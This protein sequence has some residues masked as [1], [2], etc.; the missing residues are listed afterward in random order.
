MVCRLAHEVSPE[1]SPLFF[2]HCRQGTV[3]RVV[4]GSRTLGL[5]ARQ[6]RYIRTSS[7]ELWRMRK[8][9]NSSQVSV[10]SCPR[11]LS[12]NDQCANQQRPSGIRLPQ[13]RWIWF[14]S[15]ALYL[16]GGWL[17]GGDPSK[18]QK[19]LPPAWEGTRQSTLA[20]PIWHTR[21]N[22]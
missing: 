16:D 3:Y 20:Q 10:A 22:W 15:W 18:A 12:V 2:R 17:L 11:E 7:H 21:S 9:A 14:L 4:L 13:N 6:A 8:A 5:H 1:L 19:V